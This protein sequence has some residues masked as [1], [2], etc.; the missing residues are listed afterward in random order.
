MKRS[1]AAALDSVALACRATA[2]GGKPVITAQAASR[3]ARACLAVSG[4]TGQGRRDALPYASFL[5]PPGASSANDGVARMVACMNRGLS[6]YRYEMMSL[7]EQSAPTA[8]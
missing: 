2:G 5:L 1:G 7:S 4:T 6:G 8:D 3:I